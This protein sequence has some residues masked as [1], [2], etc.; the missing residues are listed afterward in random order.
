VNMRLVSKHGE[1]LDER[2]TATGSVGLSPIVATF[3]GVNAEHGTATLL[4]DSKGSSL[5]GRAVLSAY[6][7]G[8]IG[9]FEGDMTITGGTGKY[10]HVH[11]HGLRF[12]GTIDRHDF[13]VH[14]ELVG[15]LEES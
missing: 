4:G 10:A 5:S 11:G 14:A 13:N 9:H 2:G 15:K 7:V 8:H 3:Y 12:K 6:T 1:T